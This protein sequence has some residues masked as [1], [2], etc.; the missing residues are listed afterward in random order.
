MIG[1]G[2]SITAAN[3]YKLRSYPFLA[4]WE[5][6]C[7]QTVVLLIG[8]CCLVSIPWHYANFFVFLQILHGGSNS[9]ATH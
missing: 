4:S 6:C 3:N 1:L 8:R 5:N 2:G 9:I 7:C